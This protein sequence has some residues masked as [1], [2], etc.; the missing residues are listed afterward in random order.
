MKRFPNL[1]SLTIAEIHRGPQ[2]FYDPPDEYFEHLNMSDNNDSAAD[3]SADSVFK[4][5][6]LTLKACVR[7]LF[8]LYSPSLFPHVKTLDIVSHPYPF[9]TIPYGEIWSQWPKLEVLSVHTSC[10]HDWVNYDADFLG[11][12][13]SEAELLRSRDLKE[14]R[15]LHLVPVKPAITTMKRKTSSNSFLLHIYTVKL[16]KC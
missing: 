3:T 12:F 8:E 11:I 5:V 15:N 4:V 7:S 10:G 9:S 14:L 6:N 1:Q 2:N 13:E 16:S